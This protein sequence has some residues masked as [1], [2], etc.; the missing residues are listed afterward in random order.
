MKMKAKPLK[1]EMWY[2]NTL[3]LSARKLC[4]VTK[5]HMRYQQPTTTITH[6][7]TLIYS[8][9]YFDICYNENETSEI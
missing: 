9:F 2:N 6:V 3:I 8:F 1:E 5:S 7:S 4:S